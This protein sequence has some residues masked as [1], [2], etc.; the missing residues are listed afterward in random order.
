MREPFKPVADLLR[1]G[2]A[3]RAF[4]AAAIELGR[5]DGILWRDVFGTLTYDPDSPPTQPGTVFDL[6]SMTKVIATTTLVM[7]AVDAG[8]LRVDDPIARWLAEWRGTDREDVTV[9]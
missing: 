6:A 7:R 9:H 8:R 4:P 2:V 1:T 5:R 3:S